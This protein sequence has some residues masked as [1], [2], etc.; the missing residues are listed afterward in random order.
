M[1]YSDHLFVFIIVVFY[2]VAGYLGFQRLLTRLRA[3]VL[4]SRPRM[5]RQ[6]MLGHWGL[7]LILIFLWL[8]T[9]RSAAALGLGLSAS[10]SFWFGVA[11]TLLCIAALAAQVTHVVG[12]DQ[13]TV[14]QH[15]RR[16]G[17]LALLLPRNSNELA[18]FYLVSVTAGTVE[19]L[20]WR[21]YLI[22]Y[23]AH[24]TSQGIAAL[25]VTIGFGLAH[26]YQGWRNIPRVTL[27]G[28]VFTALYLLTGSIWLSM[29]L[30]IAVDALQGRLAYEIS[31]RSS[32]GL[33]ES[34]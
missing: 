4:P 30:H 22:W 31:R 3:G 33:P 27:V 17:R 18:M 25:V 7:A 29:L 10:A 1:L 2:P 6:T 15:S 32:Y 19:E 14:D 16:Y 13:S 20:L 23:V 26:G 11:I 12:A 9:G 21:G 5:Y 24:Y 8:A 34:A 28:A